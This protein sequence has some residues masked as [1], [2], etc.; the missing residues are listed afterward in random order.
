[1]ENDLVYF[2]KRRKEVTWWVSLEAFCTQFIGVPFLVFIWNL[3]WTRRKVTKWRGFWSMMPF[4]KSWYDLF[5]SLWY[6][7]TN[8]TLDVEER[9]CFF[10]IN[11]IALNFLQELHS[12]VKIIFFISWVSKC[13]KNIKIKLLLFKYIWDLSQCRK[14]DGGAAQ[15]AN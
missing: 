10:L 14:V 7:E 5:F 13:F 8:I 15:L 2:K 11:T 1:V 12:F 4:V 9:R 6:A 3:P